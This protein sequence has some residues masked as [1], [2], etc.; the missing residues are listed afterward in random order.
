MDQ[1]I[2]ESLLKIREIEDDCRAQGIS[3]SNINDLK[4]AM[5]DKLSESCIES[6]FGDD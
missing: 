4:V 5:Y 3:E 1:S 6:Y 2:I